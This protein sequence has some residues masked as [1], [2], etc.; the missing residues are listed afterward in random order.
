MKTEIKNIAAMLATAIYADGVFDEAEQITLDEI[1]DALELDKAKFEAEMNAAIEKVDQMDE[2]A[3]TE[4]L[5]EAAA[6][7]ADDEIGI[8]FEATLQLVLADGVL[9]RCEVDTLLVIADALGIDDVDAI[10]LLADMAHSEE[11][12]TVELGE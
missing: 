10:L 8:V 11:E 4:Y 7:V 2:D 3:A 12:L 5:Q 1:Q 6:A 9:S